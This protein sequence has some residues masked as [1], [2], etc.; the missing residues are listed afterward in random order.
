MQVAEPAA[1]AFFHTEPMYRELTKL[2]WKDDLSDITNEDVSRAL[3]AAVFKM[4]G[5]IDE[6]Y[7]DN[8]VASLFKNLSKCRDLASRIDLSNTSFAL[9]P[10]R[11]PK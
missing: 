9:G 8:Y 7:T 5:A 4:M 10:S 6:I 11:D 1:S 2:G 3:I